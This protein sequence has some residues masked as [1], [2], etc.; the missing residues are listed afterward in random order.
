MGE[1]LDQPD[2]DRLSNSGHDDGD[3][4]GRLLGGERTRCRGGDENVDLESDQ[5]GRERLKSLGSALRVTDLQDDVAALDVTELAETLKERSESDVGPCSFPESARQEAD[6]PD[7]PRRLRLGSERRG[8]DAGSQ[9]GEEL[10]SIQWV[11]D[12]AGSGDVRPDRPY[13]RRWWTTGLSAREAGR[14]R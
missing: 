13:Y 12:Q 3:R 8:Q 9:R 2:L 14:Q 4:A 6:P 10:P 7:L 11:S 1:A 5:L